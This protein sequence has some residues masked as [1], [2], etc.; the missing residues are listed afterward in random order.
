MMTWQNVTPEVSLH[1][2][3]TIFFSAWDLARLDERVETLS[4]CAA[5]LE[6]RMLDPGI[7]RIRDQVSQGLLLSHHLKIEY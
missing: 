2:S 3:Q 4:A 7:P 1:V 5:S 6:R